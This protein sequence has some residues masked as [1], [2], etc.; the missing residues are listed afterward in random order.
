MSPS[1]R[2]G[3]GSS[4]SSPGATTSTRRLAA[5]QELAYASRQ[6]TAIEV[7]GTYYRTSSPRCSPRGRRDAGRSSSRSRPPASPRTE[8]LAT[9][10]ESIE[11][12][13]NSGIGEL[14]N[15]TRPAGLAVHA[16]QAF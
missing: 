15:E 8:E 16:D 14:G 1:I 6:L 9:A 2:A 5:P 11:R 3:I 4:T 12:F 13:V 7:N 10:G